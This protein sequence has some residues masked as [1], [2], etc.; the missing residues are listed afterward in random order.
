MIMSWKD[1]YGITKMKILIAAIIYIIPLCGE[2]FVMSIGP[3]PCVSG[4]CQPV[5]T[6]FCFPFPL[7]LFS[8]GFFSPI[9]KILMSTQFGFFGVFIVL[10]LGIAV[11]V[12]IAYNISCLIVTAY[13]KIRSR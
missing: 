3:S 6:M 13:H 7:L 1:F 12:F 10:L 4:D 8:F 11:S 9:S 2:S 5:N